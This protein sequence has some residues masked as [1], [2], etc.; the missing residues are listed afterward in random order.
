MRRLFPLTLLLLLLGAGSAQALTL[1]S[2]GPFSKPTYVTSDPGDANRLFVT[3]REGKIQL[4]VGGIAHTFV[5][6][7]GEVECNGSCQGERGLMSVAPA[8]DFDTSGHLFVQY[9]NDETG[10]IHVDELTAAPDRETA[11]TSTLASVF[12]VAHSQQAN[13]NG[14]QLQFGPD[15]MLYSSTGDG[16]GGNDELH[17]SQNPASLLGKILRVSPQAPATPQVWSLGLRNPF[18]FSFDRET[19]DMAIG[20]VGQGAREEIDLARSPGPG[21]VGGE[22]AN[23]GWNCREGFLAGPASDEGC[24]GSMPSDFVEP[25]FDYPHSKEADVPG[26]ASRC[27]IIGGYVVRD[28]NLG[29][30]FGHY[31]Y[32]DLCSGAIRALR[33]PAAGEAT[34]S[35]DC[36]TGLEVTNPVS[37]GEDAARRLYVVTEGGEVMRLAGQPPANCPAPAP[38]GSG[39]SGTGGSGGT[40]PAPTVTGAKNK[41]N[42]KAKGHGK[43]KS[44]RPATLTLDPSRTAVRR[45]GRVVLTAHLSPCKGRA[46][47][48]VKLRRGGRPNGS[49]SLGRHC[50]ASFVRR[51]RHRSTFTAAVA[52]GAG[53]AA[54]HSPRLRVGVLPNRDR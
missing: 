15:G 22:N 35:G 10:T 44:P 29:E 53:F 40:A 16:G 43:S 17:N 21:L 20:D 18:R 39:S 33:L 54:A 47:E 19:G 41:R 3:E 4:L 5:D 11:S 2:L 50:T 27:A 9:A 42:G 26:G 6:L 28:P 30:L 1:E 38:A 7:S 49:A 37:F 14:G 31:L 52:A 8:P 34:A 32:A 51:I 23:Y 13:H 48:R 24:A 25:V 36:W 12:T 46:G 45:G